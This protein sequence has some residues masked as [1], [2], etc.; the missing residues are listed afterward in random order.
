MGRTKNR[1]VGR[2]GG[3]FTPEIMQVDQELFV[4]PAIDPDQTFREDGTG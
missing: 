4:R 3:V 1:I 2:D